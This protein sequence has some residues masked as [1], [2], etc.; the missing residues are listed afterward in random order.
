MHMPFAELSIVLAMLTSVSANS[1]TLLN[2][3]R[4]VDS[5]DA[6]QVIALSWYGWFNAFTAFIAMVLIVSIWRLWPQSQANTV[7]VSGHLPK[8]VDGRS[9]EM[10][11]L[12]RRLSESE[13]RYQSIVEDQTEMV[14]RFD[15]DGTLTFANR[16]YRDTEQSDG[17]NARWI[18]RVFCD[19]PGP[20]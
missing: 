7:S 20:P 16:S 15:A 9:E 8:R 17:K 19:P 5:A 10:E 4:F 6:R 2:V 18:Q 12:T 13:L 14:I 11:I 1:N 3:C